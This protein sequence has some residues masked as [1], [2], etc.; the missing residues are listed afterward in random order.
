MNKLYIFFASRTSRHDMKRAGLPHCGALQVLLPEQLSPNEPATRL[1]CNTGRGPDCSTGAGTPCPYAQRHLVPAEG[2][3]RL[4]AR[5][6]TSTRRSKTRS[7]DHRALGRSDGRKPWMG[8]IRAANSLE[9][10]GVLDGTAVRLNAGSGQY[11]QLPSQ[12]ELRALQWRADQQQCSIPVQRSCQIAS[13]ACISL[14]RTRP[15][16]SGQ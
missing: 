16:G 14:G 10:L 15:A 12:Q 6:G 13:T 8:T 11:R 7:R 3:I 9:G 4:A 1:Q 2:A 5:T